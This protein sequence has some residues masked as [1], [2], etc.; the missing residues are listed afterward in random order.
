M[1]LFVCSVKGK[2]G[3]ENRKLVR[4]WA[5]KS[6]DEFIICPNGTQLLR[7]VTLTGL[8]RRKQGGTLPGHG[9]GESDTG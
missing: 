1:N 7:G 3:G 2:G 8:L 5:G 6:Q 4:G 9:S